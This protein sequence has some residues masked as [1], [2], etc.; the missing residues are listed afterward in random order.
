MRDKTEE[1]RVF[2]ALLHTHLT[3]VAVRVRHFRGGHEL[4]PIVADEHYDFNFQE[5]RMIPEEV[6][7]LPV[8]PFFIPR[9]GNKGTHVQMAT[10]I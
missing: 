10:R 9:A 8:R 6:V 7:V 3:G 2:G 1:I 4:P 5:T